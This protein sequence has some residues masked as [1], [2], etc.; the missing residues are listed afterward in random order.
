MGRVPSTSVGGDGL[1]ADTV[2]GESDGAD[3]EVFETAVI[4]VGVSEMIV[5]AG[6]VV[7]AAAAVTGSA[8]CGTC[9]SWVSLRRVRG[10]IRIASNKDK[11]AHTRGMS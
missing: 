1:D 5:G 2:G 6:E 9:C 4:A 7:D 11:K 3:E 10:L 8:E